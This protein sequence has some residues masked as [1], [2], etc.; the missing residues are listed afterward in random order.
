[1]R[2]MVRIEL[3]ARLRVSDNVIVTFRVR[4]RERFSVGFSE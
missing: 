1:M 4:V 2:V 3:C